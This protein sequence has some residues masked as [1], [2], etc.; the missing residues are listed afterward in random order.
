MTTHIK[1]VTSQRKLNLA[2][3]HLRFCN[4]DGIQFIVFIAFCCLA[5][6]PLLSD[7]D[8]R[9]TFCK[10]FE[11]MKINTND[12]SVCPQFENNQNERTPRDVPDVFKLLGDGDRIKDN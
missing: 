12:F 6:A 5:F 8:H 11:F 7:C 1:Y 4:L 3:R 10:F 9:R 2:L